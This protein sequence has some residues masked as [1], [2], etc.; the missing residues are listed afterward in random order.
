MSPSPY[1]ARYL[2][3]W[4]TTQTVAHAEKSVVD[5]VKRR[6]ESGD[7]GDYD[8]LLFKDA[9]RAQ[10]PSG[11]RISSGGV[12]LGVVGATKSELVGVLDKM[13]T[14][15]ATKGA[16]YKYYTGVW[17]GRHV[18]VVETGSGFERVKQGTEA[19]LQAFRPARVVSVG[20]AKALVPSLSAGALFVPN[21]L[22]KEDGSVFDLSRPMLS[23]PQ[24]EEKEEDEA[25]FSCED[26][27]IKKADSAAFNPDDSAT[28]PS[29]S[30]PK[31]NAPNSLTYEFLQRF[32]TGAL[33]SVEREVVK[34]VEK[35]QLADEF[36]ASALDQCAWS[37]AEAC[38]ASGTPFLSLRVIYD[39]R[40]QAGSKEAARVVGS[41]GQSVA[42][43]LGA[44]WGAVS[45]RPSSALD[46]YKLK[47]Q[48]LEAADK[49]AKA[50]AIILSSVPQ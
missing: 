14:L 37:V 11:D 27:G 34:K 42:R 38:G 32:A 18:A 2:L 35:K 5:E 30:E 36:G 47:E 41:G 33:I 25:R 22:L 7:L 39:P 40:V 29:A 24:S 26:S 10:R 43:S 44:L 6:F 3:N 31:S 9:F 16:S 46:V 45:K 48:A 23:A 17:K 8:G 50:L 19:L 13:G 15:K 12:D 1:L 20:F 4:L 49:L 28:D 21:R